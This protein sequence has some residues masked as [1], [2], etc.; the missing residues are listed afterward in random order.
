VM[1]ELAQPGPLAVG[2]KADVYFPPDTSST[3]K[4]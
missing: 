1:V 2:M 4:R 3:D